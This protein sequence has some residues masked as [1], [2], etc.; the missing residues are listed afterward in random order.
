MNA[1]PQRR[2]RLE[3]NELMEPKTFRILSLDGGGGIMGAFSAAV[4]AEFENVTGRRIVEHFDLMTGNV[5]GR[6]H[7]H[8]PGDGGD[9]GGYQSVLRDGGAED[10]PEAERGPGL[11]GARA[12]RV[13]TEVPERGPGAAIKTVVGER[14]LKEVKTRLVIPTYDVNTGKVYLFKTPHHPWSL[15]H[16]DL[17]AL[18]AVLATSAAP[19]GTHDPRPGH[20]HRRGPLGEPSGDGRRGRGTRLP[21]P[22]TG[23]SPDAEPEHDQLPVPPRRPRSTPRAGRP[24]HRSSSIRSCSARPRRR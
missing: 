20:V 17:P 7:R 11:A 14:P 16:V 3:S 1:P 15:N 18:D 4:P 19:T 24:G 6:D 9:G 5:Q 12:G 22:G 8:R 10:L 2:R 13:Q 21:G 23:A